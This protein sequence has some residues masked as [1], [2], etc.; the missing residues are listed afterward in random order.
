[1]ASTPTMC[2]HL[3]ASSIV[4]CRMLEDGLVEE[5]QQEKERVEQKQRD[6]RVERE[7]LGEEWTPKFFE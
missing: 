5:A 3:T 6:T 2:L 1:M 4:C 7:K